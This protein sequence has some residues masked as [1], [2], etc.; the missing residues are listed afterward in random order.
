MG[1]VEGAVAL[2][3]HDVPVGQFAHLRDGFGH[4][5]D[6]LAAD[7]GGGQRGG[8]AFDD[9]P[10]ADEFERP[11]FVGRNRCGLAVRAVLHVHARAGAHLDPAFDLE[12][13]Q[14]LAHR[15]PAHAELAREVAL[16]R[17]ARAGVELALRD[18]RAQLIGDLPVQALRFDGL[19]GH[20]EERRGLRVVLNWT[21]GQANSE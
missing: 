2:Q 20:G 19:H 5:V 17:Q 11:P 10:R 1:Q 7:V 16:G 14:R 18:E 9:A 3:R 12:R 13:D 8:F 21:S 6:V 4:R 15:G